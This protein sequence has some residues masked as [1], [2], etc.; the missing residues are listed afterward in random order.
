[1]TARNRAVTVEMGA[2]LIWVYR[3]RC[4]D[5]IHRARIFL[6][7][8]LC[9]RQY[10]GSRTGWESSQRAMQ[11]Q[12]QQ[13][14]ERKPPR[15]PSGLRRAGRSLQGRLKPKSAENESHVSQKQP[16]KYLCLTQS[17]AQSSPKEAWPC[18]NTAMDFKGRLG[19]LFS[20][21]PSSKK[22]GRCTLRA[23]W[24]QWSGPAPTRD[25]EK[26]GLGV[27]LQEID[28]IMA[29]PS[30]RLLHSS[31]NNE[32]AFHRLTRK[33]LLSEKNKA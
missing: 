24:E 22:S 31:G 2:V 32:K 25:R 28:K 10:R 19:S 18:S 7:K 21:T 15:Q 16:L 9:G 8:C 12:P 26:T 4:Q 13:R 1:M 11:G 17:L 20:Y 29:Y 23:A 30:N 14:A 3:S 5:G 33:D 6:W 27:R